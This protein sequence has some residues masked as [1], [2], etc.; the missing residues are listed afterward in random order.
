MK[1]QLIEAARARSFKSQVTHP[2]NTPATSLFYY[3]W[4]CELKEWLIYYYDIWPQIEVSNAGLFPEV[5]PVKDGVFDISKRITIDKVFSKD[6]RLQCF[7]VA[8]FEA[9]K[10]INES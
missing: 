3:L 4:L 8:L 7:E 2:W 5:L 9:L 1:E 6:E 10:L